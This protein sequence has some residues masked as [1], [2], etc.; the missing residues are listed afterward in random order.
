MTDDD[1]LLDRLIERLYR[2]RVRLGAGLYE[3]AVHA[4][5]VAVARTAQAE[6]EKRA[7]KTDPEPGGVVVRFPP[8][9][10]GGRQ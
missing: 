6:A 1:D 2:L 8:G 7:G 4:C 9:G 5:L 3:D 10:R